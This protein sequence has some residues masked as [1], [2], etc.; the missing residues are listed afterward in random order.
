MLLGLRAE[1]LCPMAVRKLIPEVEVIDDYNHPSS[2]QPGVVARQPDI[3]QDRGVP[4]WSKNGTRKTGA[5]WTNRGL[6]LAGLARI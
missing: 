6:K 1:V 5:R 2:F 3:E 4:A